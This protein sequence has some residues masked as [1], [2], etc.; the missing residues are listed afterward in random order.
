MKMKDLFFAAF[1]A[2]PILIF[3][4][5]AMYKRDF[6]PIHYENF[7]KI[8]DGMSREDVRDL[9][10]CGP[11]THE[12]GVTWVS[13]CNYKGPDPSGPWRG[14]RKEIS[15]NFVGDRVQAKSIKDRMIVHED[16]ADRV[17]RWL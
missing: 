17:R 1:L 15:I 2:G 4:F 8:Q 11:C 10:G 7:D 6:D 16:T 12:N 13:L 5:H 14:E 3:T 9:L